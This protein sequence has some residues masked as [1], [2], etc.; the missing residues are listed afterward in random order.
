MMK[1]D[2]RIIGVHAR[3]EM[4]FHTL[5]RLGLSKDIVSYD[6]RPNGG[7]CLYTARKAWLSPVEDG[8]T[9]RIVLADDAYVCN[10][11]EDI[12]N[13]IINAHPNKVISCFPF[14]YQRKSDYI[15]GLNTPYVRTHLA[16]GMGIIMPVKYIEDCFQWIEKNLEPDAPDDCAISLYCGN[17]GIDIITTIPPTIQHI[18]DDSIL[19]PG[20]CVR[21][22]EY[23]TD[24][25]VADWGCE[26]IA[27]M[28]IKPK[29]LFARRKTKGGNKNERTF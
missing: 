20:L 18:G 1:A 13:Q 6:D 15:D 7:A 22:T 3:D 12:C 19:T 14:D 5:G 11:F 29:R 25:P 21:R 24:D 9:H 4:I 26:N 8:I 16:A 28:E 10:R 23:Y 27:P 17:H 2:I